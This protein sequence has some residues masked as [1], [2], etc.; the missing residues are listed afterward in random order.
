MLIRPKLHCYWVYYNIYC[1]NNYRIRSP[2]LLYHRVSQLSYY[3]YLHNTRIRFEAIKFSFIV[4][5]PVIITIMYLQSIKIPTLTSIAVNHQ[6]GDVPVSKKNIT[7]LDDLSI[8]Q[9]FY[10]IQN[11][12]EKIRLKRGK[13][14]N[15]FSETNL[16]IFKY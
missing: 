5:R 8:L 7:E 12:R 14:F 1:P 2:L 13:N 16:I 15:S 4:R 9:I 6:A 10:Y 3:Y 11:I